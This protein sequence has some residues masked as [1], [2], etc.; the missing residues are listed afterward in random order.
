MD[1]FAE[2]KKIEEEA[3]KEIQAA[4]IAGLLEELKVKYLGRKGKLT[5][6]LRSIGTLSPADKP[7]LGKEGKILRN[8]IEQ[9][10]TQRSAS[11]QASEE[12]LQLKQGTLDTTLPGEMPAYGHLHPLTKV[13]DQVLEIFKGLGF[14]IAEG[15]EIENEFHNFEALNMPANHPSRDMQDTFYLENGLLL[16]T[17]TSPVQIRVMKNHTP[18]LRIVAPGK[19]YRCDADV[20]HSPIFHQIEGFMVDYHI[21]FSHLKGM[22]TAFLNQTFGKE[23]KVRFRPSYFPF[24]EPSAEVDISCVICNGNG[25]R[26]CSESGWVEILGAGMIN[27][28]VFEACGYP[29]DKYT[30]FAFGLGI[31]RIAM[32]KYGINDI[33]LFYENDIRFIQQF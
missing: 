3:L 15:P 6:I 16:R 11:L 1:I 22:L 23:T 18:P 19:V 21:N 32:L 4:A 26:V 7:R 8:K 17:H 12:Q 30:G 9:A 27:P 14:K 5:T 13:L 25:C 20:S 31:E 24:T 10:L 29:A 33:R 2:L 28:K